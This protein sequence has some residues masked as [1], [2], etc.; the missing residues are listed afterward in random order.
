MK[1]KILGVSVFLIL[2]VISCKDQSKSNP[3]TEIQPTTAE[4]NVNDMNSFVSLFEIPATDISRAIRFYHTIL[5]LDIEKM[6]MPGMEMGIF[7]YQNQTVM[8]VIMKGEDFKPSAD[9][10]TIYLNGGNNLQTILDKVEKNGG[11]I[12]VPKTA[13]ADE[14]GFFALFLDTEGNKL[15]LHS[16]H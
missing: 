16:P 3:E 8:G 11:S 6:E 7:P 9:G 14:S 15:G 13:H 2:S 5:E 10:V 1:R 4:K 12:I